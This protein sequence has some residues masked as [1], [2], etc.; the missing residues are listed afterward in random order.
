MSTY[1]T[2]N[3]ATGQALRTFSFWSAEAIHT[4]LDHAVR[5]QHDW[6]ARPFADRAAVLF[7]IA[8][9]LESNGEALASEMTLEMGKP[10]A[11]ARGEVRKCAWVCRHYAEH[12][13][14]MLAPRAVEASA[15]INE[16]HFAPLGVIFSVMPWN[17]PVWQVLRFAAPAWMAGNAVVMKHAPNTFGTAEKLAALCHGAGLPEGLLIDARI[18]VPDIPGVIADRR[19]AAVTVTGSDRAGRAVAKVAGDHLKKCVLEL[20]G[21]D[22]FIVLA[23]ADLDAAV[24]AAV[25]SRCLNSGQSCIAAKRFIVEAPVYDDFVSRFIDRLAAHTVGDPTSADTTIGPLARPDLRDQLAAQV[26]ASIQ[27]GARVLWEGRCPAEGNA[28]FA[29]MV[30]GDIPDGCPAADEELFGPVA[31]VWRVNSAEAAVARANASRFGLSA[32]LWTTNLDRARV[33]AARLQTGGVFVNQ[34][35]Y[36]DPRL[37]FGGI[38]DSGYGRELGVFGIRE[39]VNVKTVSIR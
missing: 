11:E 18:D 2:T 8:D 29:P 7:A 6:Q 24:D 28:F 10:I 4:A 12:A 39:F 19:V 36:S 25:T 9:A 27:A 16:V 1:T 23:D 26:A 20:G 13:E 3:P 33:L 21:S 31:S 34:F 17:F 32:S 30:L 22:P 38:K 15:P 14:Q 35:S 5:A 37:P